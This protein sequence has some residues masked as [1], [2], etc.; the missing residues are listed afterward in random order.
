[1]ASNKT[2]NQTSE[3]QDDN[4]WPRFLIM[5]AAIRNVPLDL[6]AF[7]LKK[8]ID[9]MANAELN[10]VKPMKSGS[11]FIEV[12]TKQQCKN[13]LKTT[14]LLGYL[15]VK[16]SPHRTLNSSKFVIKCEELD[17]MDEEEIKKELQPQGIIAVKRISIR[18]SLYVLT[19]KGQNI[20]TKKINIGYLRKE[21]RPY[22]PNPQRYNVFNAR[23]L[24]IP[25]IRVTVKPFV[26]DVVKKDTI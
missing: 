20:P 17:K 21:T 15:P 2:S 8:E 11:V 26:L 23:N 10:H 1:M 3:N 14:K 12:E 19:I 4:Q 22:I 5:E 24:D 9:G 25:R 18:Y 7:V 6:N 13:L 16:V